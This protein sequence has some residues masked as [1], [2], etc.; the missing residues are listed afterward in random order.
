M[1]I[2][3]DANQI[4]K[5]RYADEHNIWHTISMR[6]AGRKQLTRDLFIYLKS[7][8]KVTGNFEKDYKETW[9]RQTYQKYVNFQGIKYTSETLSNRRQTKTNYFSHIC[10]KNLSILVSM[11]GFINILITEKRTFWNEMLIKVAGNMLIV[12]EINFSPVNA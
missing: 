8:A 2:P 6:A 5:Y 4:Q 1:K 12:C 7:I 10:E 11:I 9:K 3:I